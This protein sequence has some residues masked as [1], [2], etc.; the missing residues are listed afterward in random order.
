MASLD[1][2]CG[3]IFISL[4][5]GM[6]QEILNKLNSFSTYLNTPH[7]EN[8]KGMNGLCPQ[9]C[10]CTYCCF[11]WE[12]PYKYLYSPIGITLPAGSLVMKN[13][14]KT[15]VWCSIVISLCML[16]LSPKK[17]NN[18]PRW[19][20]FVNQKFTNRVL[21]CCILSIEGM[22]EQVTWDA[23]YC[24]YDCNRMVHNVF[25]YD[26]DGRVFI[27]AANFPGSWGD[28][29]LISHFSSSLKGMVIIIP[30]STKHCLEV[31][32]L[33]MLLLD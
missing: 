16:F 17:C 21:G 10:R 4:M 26:Q 5:T 2:F 14:L 1:G 33:W 27:C 6:T 24:R 11:I 12:M 31:G 30:V 7:M 23:L 25:P 8:Q 18:M 3:S 29:S 15:F 9:M 20:V 28:G 22:V 19:S 32:S 13:M